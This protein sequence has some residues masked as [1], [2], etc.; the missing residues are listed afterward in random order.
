MA[1]K[2][3]FAVGD[4]VGKAD[5]THDGDGACE[6]RGDAVVIPRTSTQARTIAKHGK[7]LHTSGTD[8]FWARSVGPR[9]HIMPKDFVI[10]E[11][12]HVG[13]G[14][15]LHENTRVAPIVPMAT[16]N[17]LAKKV[18]EN[19]RTNHPEFSCARFA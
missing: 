1:N 4:L 6:T 19:L 17:R 15:T 18:R 11:G 13:N 12:T 7:T 16:S 14:R 10:T 8:F 5:G 9:H 3:A 2:S